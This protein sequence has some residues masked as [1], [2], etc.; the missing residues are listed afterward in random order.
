MRVACLYDLHGNLPALEAVLSEIRDVGVDRVVVG[1]DVLP[2]P[3]PR[4]SLDLLASLDLPVDCITGNG[5]RE[6]LAA[7]RGELSPIIPE[8]VRESMLWNAQ[9]LRDADVSVVAAWPLTVTLQ[10]SDL[11]RVLFCHATP[12]NDM[13]IFVATTAVEKLLPLFEPLAADVVVCGH[14]HMQFD[15]RVGRVRVVNAGSVGM[16]FQEPGGYWL[17]IDNGFELRRTDYDL[18]AAA[19]RVRATTY[20][21]AEDFAAKNILNPPSMDSMMAA[22]SSAELK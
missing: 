7:R 9:Q 11:G 21:L 3:M 22:F 4:E 1:G 17:L 15:R 13:D 6:T 19:A 16:P 18:E 8:Y 14:T 10:L 5:D 12:R 2:G 20:P